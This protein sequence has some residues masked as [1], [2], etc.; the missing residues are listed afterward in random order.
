[1]RTAVS[2]WWR[3]AQRGGVK[4]LFEWSLGLTEEKEQNMQD[5]YEGRRVEG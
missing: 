4:G 2:V 5:G 3:R 1:M